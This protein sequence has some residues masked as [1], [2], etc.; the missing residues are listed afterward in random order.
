MMHNKFGPG[1][2]CKRNQSFGLVRLA[3][4][5][6]LLLIAACTNE[7]NTAGDSQEAFYLSMGT[8]VVGFD[9]DTPCFSGDDWGSSL[10]VK[11]NGQ[12]V[13]TMKRGFSLNP[14]GN[15]REANTLAF[16]AS[17]PM[18]EDVYMAFSRLVQVGERY[19]NTVLWRKKIL[20]DSWIK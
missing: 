20:G 13:T 12:S 5:L 2:R 6:P 3:S 17:E 4:F 10:E 11:V 15:L 8:G 9:P 1:D 7:K 19:E 16:S 14:L 18:E